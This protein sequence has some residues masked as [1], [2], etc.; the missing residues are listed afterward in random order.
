MVIDDYICFSRRCTR[1]VP[2]PS[3]SSGLFV[4]IFLPQ[5]PNHVQQR[6][7]PMCIN[8]FLWLSP[9]SA[10]VNSASVLVLKRNTP[11]KQTSQTTAYRAKH[12]IPA[13][14]AAPS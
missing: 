14:P 4:S 2:V 13:Q 5:Y 11:C 8:I 9:N 3:G 12:P 10:C 7:I 6:G 1:N